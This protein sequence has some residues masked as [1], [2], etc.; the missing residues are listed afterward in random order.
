MTRT[1]TSKLT[2][3]HQATIP[4]SVRQSLQLSAGD[5]IVFDISDSHV[6]IRKA[7]PLDVLFAQSL[8][9]TLTEWGTEADERA[10]RDL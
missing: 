3:K 10:Y 8:E 4:E 2:T 5:A 9:G 7:Q 6:S 1:A